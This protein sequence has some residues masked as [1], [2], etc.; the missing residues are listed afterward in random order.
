MKN[1]NSLFPEFIGNQNALQQLSVDIAAGRFP[2]ALLLEGPKGCGKKTLARLLAQAAVCTDTARRPCN[3]CA[4]C[5]KAA[6][7]IHPDIE[8]WTG[9]ADGNHTFRVDTVRE[10]REGADVMPNEAPVRVLILCDVHTMT[11]AA[12]NALLKILE[13]PPRH[14]VF[15]LTCENK[16]ML[17]STIRSRVRTVTLSGVEWEEARP[18]LRER[19]PQVD[20]RVLQ[21]AFAIA[22]GVIGK[23][24]SEAEDT[25]L[26]KVLDI[27]PRL[28]KALASRSEWSVMQV[29]AAMEKDRETMR[30]VLEALQVVLRDALTLHYGGQETISVAPDEARLLATTLSAQRL[31]AM[32]R[33]VEQLLLDISRNMNQNLLLTRLSAKL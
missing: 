21:R 32:I 25:T 7:G 26:Q 5:R 28:A 14:I 22:D 19:L 2:H 13:E 33:E 18:L 12:Q 27:V 6:Q 3:V 20:E 11:P 24:L 1:C 31:T 4:M 10:I 15:I 23:V 9:D 16:A 30:G 8:E 29:A 17:L